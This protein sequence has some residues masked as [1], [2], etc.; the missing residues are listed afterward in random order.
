MEETRAT[1]PTGEGMAP[2]YGM[3]ATVPFRGMVRDM[4]KRYMD[5][6]YEV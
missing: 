6:L 4:L 2:V 5:L 3:A 1:K